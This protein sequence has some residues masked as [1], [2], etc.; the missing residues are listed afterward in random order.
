MT[1]T[2]NTAYARLIATA[3]AGTDE[4]RSAALLVDLAHILRTAHR[5]SGDD[6]QAVI[7][8]WWSTNSPSLLPAHVAAARESLAALGHSV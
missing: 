4:Q 6:P 1:A 2:R 8:A 5:A 7:R 3:L